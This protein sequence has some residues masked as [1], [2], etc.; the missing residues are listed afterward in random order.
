V[1]VRGGDADLY[2][3]QIGGTSAPLVQSTFLDLQAQY[4]HDG[5]RIALV[6]FRAGGPAI[7]LANADGSNVTRLTH[8][9][10]LRQGYPNWSP[11]DKWIVF[12]SGDQNR[13]RDI[14]VIGASGS[15]LRQITSDPGDDMTP[16][17]SQD[18]RHIYF[19]SNRTG[20]EE[21]WRIP[22]G[23]GRE[24]QLTK[25]G[26]TF[27][28]ESLDGAML[29][30]KRATGDTELLGRPIGGGEERL[31]LPCVPIFGY[32]VVRG[33]IVHHDCGSQDFGA[34]ARRTLYQWE[35]ATGAR[36]AIGSVEADWIG[37]L[38]GSPDGKYIVYGRGIATS[39][40]MMIENFR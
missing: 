13:R 18:G 25:Q 2:R 27:P 31:I 34:S 17:W 12:D 6:S 20:R 10:G 35:E 24:E 9:P 4:S 16:S 1:Y 5:R 36:R 37:G 33:G 11:D 40:L 7:W 23:G 19:T 30:Y 29:Y 3:L 28:F 38:A 14:Y 8:G 15:G 26:G 22:A 32:A 21:I 39:D